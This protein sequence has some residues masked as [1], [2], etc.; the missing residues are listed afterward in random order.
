MPKYIFNGEEISEDFVNQ[1]FEASGLSTLQEYIESK[2]G[3]EVLPDENFQQDG[4][5][6]ADAPSETG[7]GPVTAAPE[8]TDLDLGTS[9]LDLIY[10]QHL[11]KLQLKEKIKLF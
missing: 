10:L 4:V 2:Q 11:K 8:S 7:L 3:L 6:G 1:A 9:L 5:A